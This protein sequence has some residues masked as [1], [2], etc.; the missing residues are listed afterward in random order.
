MDLNI[1]FRRKVRKVWTIKNRIL[2][3]KFN[4]IIYYY[5]HGQT[6]SE[7]KWKDSDQPTI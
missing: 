7:K 2:L 1:S 4:P 3:N 6:W 5:I